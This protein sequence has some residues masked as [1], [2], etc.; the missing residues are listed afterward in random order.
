MS[1]LKLTTPL[2]VLVAA[3]SGEI[4]GLVCNTLELK[5]NDKCLWQALSCLVAGG[6]VAICTD[7]LV[8]GTIVVLETALYATGNSPVTL[9]IVPLVNV[10]GETALLTTML[11]QLGKSFS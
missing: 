4:A 7:D 11:T 9:F 2:T 10:A 5:E 8:G 1:A 3:V 6:I